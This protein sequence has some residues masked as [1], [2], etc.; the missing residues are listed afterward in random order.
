MTQNPIT[1]AEESQPSETSVGLV[2]LSKQKM[3][4]EYTYDFAKSGGAV[5][6]QYLNGPPMP[7]NFIVTGASFIDVLTAVTGG[8]GATVSLGIESA[9]DVRTAQTLA[10]APALSAV[11]VVDLVTNPAFA[12]ETTYIKTTAARRPLMTIGSAALT[13][14]RFVLLVE[15]NL[16]K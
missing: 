13:A 2:Y 9:T 8:G 15:G 5:G 3:S 1:G 14:G 16:S 12:E 7:D 4:F 11:A 6:T 10:T